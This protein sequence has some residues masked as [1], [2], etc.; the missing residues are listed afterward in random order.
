MN[1]EILIQCGNFYLH[2]LQHNNSLRE[3][4][5]KSLT[6][7][8]NRLWHKTYRLRHACSWKPD[9]NKTCNS[10]RTPIPWTAHSSWKH[11]K[12][13]S[14]LYIWGGSWCVIP[15]PGYTCWP[16]ISWKH[17]LQSSSMT[18]DHNKA[19]KHSKRH[20]TPHHTTQQGCKHSTIDLCEGLPHLRT[21][22][23]IMMASHAHRFTGITMYILISPRPEGVLGLARTHQILSWGHERICPQVLGVWG[24]VLIIQGRTV[25]VYL[26]LLM[27]N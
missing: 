1:W 15:L 23:S 16:T 7:S 4:L 25:F 27:H 17:P 12:I 8:F 6:P 22:V 9:I 13:H 19:R 21:T 10:V 2:M 26:T 14:W 24:W 20:S 11:P 5:N 3:C 18:L